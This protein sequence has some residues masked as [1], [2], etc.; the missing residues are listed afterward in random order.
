[1]VTAQFLQYRIKRIS[2]MPISVSKATIGG[3]GAGR[4]GA[5]PEV[6]EFLWVGSGG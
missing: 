5:E 1:M 2:F 3:R 4:G 6:I